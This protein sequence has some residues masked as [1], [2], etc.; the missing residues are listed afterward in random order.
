MASK[1]KKTK[2]QK[3]RKKAGKKTEKPSL[4]RE[5]TKIVTCFVVLVFIVVTAAMFADYFLN[6][7]VAYKN[8]SRVKTE[9]GVNSDKSVSAS[10]GSKNRKTVSSV[11]KK[12]KKKNILPH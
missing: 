9:T 11:K 4:K 6:K 5:L 8:R 10:H 1:T 7:R 2:T 12:L 3:T